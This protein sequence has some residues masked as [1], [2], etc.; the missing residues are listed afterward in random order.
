[1]KAPRAAVLTVA[2]LVA[3]ANAARAQADDA[4]EALVREGVAL[5]RAG[6]DDDA[7]VVLRRAWAIRRSPRASGQLALA[8]QALGRWTRAETLLRA[9]LAAPDDPWVARN[10]AVLDGA[11]A[12]ALRHLG[13]LEV[14]GCDG[15]AALSVDGEP[16][17]TP[18]GIRLAAGTARVTCTRGA[19]ESFTRVAEVAAGAVVRVTFPL[20]SPRGGGA[21]PASRRVHPLVWIGAATAGAAAVAVGT[22]FAAGEADAGAY[23]RAC[24]EAPSPDRAGCVAWRVDA[25]SRLDAYSD[26]MV[27]GWALLGAG[28]VAAGVG[29]GLTLAAPRASATTVQ[30]QASPRGIGLHVTF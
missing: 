17:A 12:V 13:T 11:L 8:E 26:A 6:R 20:S 1:M 2:A 23:D 21:L 19:G 28:V 25:Q 27:A 30:L 14:R 16:V 24:V 7:A 18:D 29:V 15:G 3:H 22:L 5:R 10:R 4:E 9:A